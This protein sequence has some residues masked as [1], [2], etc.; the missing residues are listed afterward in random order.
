MKRD[1]ELARDILL[2]IEASPEATPH[3]DKLELSRPVTSGEFWGHV[4]LLADAGYLMP[5]KEWRHGGLVMRGGLEI[6]SAGH[7]FLDATRDPAIWRKAK[8]GARK[9]GGGSLKLLGEIAAAL[10][11]SEAVKLGIL[12][13]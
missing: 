6:S 2:A 11:K 9:I 4:R 3:W 7:D 5:L 12:P 10:V 8:A 1:L 13:P